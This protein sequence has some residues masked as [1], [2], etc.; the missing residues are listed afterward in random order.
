MWNYLFSWHCRDESK[1]TNSSYKDHWGPERILGKNKQAGTMSGINVSKDRRRRGDPKN[2]SLPLP[3]RTGSQ[4]T[5]KREGRSSDCFFFLYNC[6]F[7]FL[8]ACLRPGRNKKTCSY[9]S[10]PKSDSLPV[11]ILERVVPLTLP[12]PS[13]SLR[14]FEGGW[15]YDSFPFVYTVL[16]VFI[17]HC[18]VHWAALVWV[19]GG[20]QGGAALYAS[21]SPH[22]QV[23]WPVWPNLLLNDM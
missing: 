3:D 1:S 7:L 17:E 6:I 4:G 10:I 13:S 23:V 11:G 5:S 21:C 8:F 19:V 22:S 12:A 18:E 9:G 14:V 20:R 15:L 16:C 2:T